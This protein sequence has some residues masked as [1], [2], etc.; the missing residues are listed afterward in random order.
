MADGKM[1]NWGEV[2]NSESDCANSKKAITTTAP[3][4]C[5]A[6]I[7]RVMSRGYVAIVAAKPAMPPLA[8]DVNEAAE[9]WGWVPLLHRRHD[10]YTWN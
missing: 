7:V 3:A 9:A 6:H 5:C 4:S 10:S 2:S 1:L 8:R